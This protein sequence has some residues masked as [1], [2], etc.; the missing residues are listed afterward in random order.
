M[1]TIRDGLKEL[2]DTLSERQVL[3]LWRIA[4]SMEPSEILTQDEAARVDQAL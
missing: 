1:S 3:A 4:A 2:I